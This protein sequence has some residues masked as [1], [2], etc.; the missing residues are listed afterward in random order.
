MIFKKPYGFLIK[1]FKLVHLFITLILTFTMYKSFSIYNFLNDYI[2]NR[3]T[4]STNFGYGD[5]YVPLF[6]LISVLLLIILYALIA[7]LFKNKKKPSKY[8][9]FSTVYFIILFILLLVFK[10]ILSG[11]EEVLLEARTARVYRDISL[12]SLIPLVPIIVVSFIR[13][14]GFNV[15]KFDFEKELKDLKLEEED[16]EE[17]EITFNLE[18][19]KLVRVIR[20]FI[21]EFKYYV[22]ENKYIVVAIIVIVLGVSTYLVISNITTD[23]NSYYKENKNFLYNNLNIN[24]KDSIVTKIDYKGDKIDNN[25]Y[26]VL[27]T[28]IE[29]TTNKEIEL[30]S[31]N[32]KLE[33][34]NTYYY[35]E[36]DKGSYFIDYG[37][38]LYGKSIKGNTKGIYTLIYKIDKKDI[39]NSYRLSLYKNTISTKEGPIDS[40]NYVKINPVLIENKTIVGNYN[41]NDNI[42]F[43]D[44]NMLNTTLKINSI[45]IKDR[46]EYDYQVCLSNND[47]RTFKDTIMISNS[48]KILLIMK[49]DYKIDKDSPYYNTSKSLSTF[50]STFS[51]IRYLNIENNYKYLNLINVTPNKLKNTYV[52]EVNKDFINS[53]EYFLAIDIRNKEYLINLK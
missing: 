17:V 48:N 22:K 14:L 42:S 39:K 32:I 19:Y 49:A 36:N 26:L 50:I 33:L 21:R 31:D 7:S 46:Y 12:M 27:Q 15:K 16:S 53:S 52:F 3:Y 2:K 13:T 10:D 5:T 41:I 30:K 47:C 37:V 23:Y 28:I 4:V 9:E 24:I 25:Y 43:V 8:Y 1:H 29:N 51:K 45:D 35:P 6:L 11:L 18:S 44:S 34:N 20:R 40:F 38:P